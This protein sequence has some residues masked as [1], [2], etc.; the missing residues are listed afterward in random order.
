MDRAANGP[1][2]GDVGALATPAGPTV[3]V[4]VVSAVRVPSREP[5]ASD[6]PTARHKPLCPS[7]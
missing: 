1:T 4:A 3:R 7:A 6:G 2:A 5:R